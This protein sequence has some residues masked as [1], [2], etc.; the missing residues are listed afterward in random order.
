[1]PR[2]NR[3]HRLQAFADRL[4]DRIVLQPMFTTGFDQASQTTDN[5]RARA[6]ARGVKAGLPDVVVQQGEP[7]CEVWIELKR[8]TKPTEAQLAVHRQMRA[9]GAKVYVMSTLDGVR[10]ALM[11]AGFRLHGNSVNIL[12]ELNE[13]LAAADDKAELPRA[14]STKPPRKPRVSPS[15][16]A[17]VWETRRGLL[18]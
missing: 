11:N 2:N 18:P 9:C 8:G 3:E 10:L 17:R 12:A 7:P 6:R 15:R 4:I 13:R 14:I 16:M 1:M 5:A